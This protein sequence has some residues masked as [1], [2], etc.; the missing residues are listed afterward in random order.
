MPVSANPLLR[1]GGDHIKGEQVF[2]S[3]SMPDA[4]SSL[5]LLVTLHVTP[6]GFLV[7]AEGVVVGEGDF[8]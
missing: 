4:D 3:A 2:A 1:L 7:G 6:C 5:T 8:H